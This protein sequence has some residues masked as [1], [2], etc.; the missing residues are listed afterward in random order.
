MRLKVFRRMKNFRIEM[1]GD[2]DS[3]K[4]RPPLPRG[5]KFLQARTPTTRNRRQGAYARQLLFFSPL[6]NRE[7]SGILARVPENAS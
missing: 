1:E 3:G 2:F 4:P 5:A 6:R 7:E